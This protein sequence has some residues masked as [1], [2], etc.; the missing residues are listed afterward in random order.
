M[1]EIKRVQLCVRASGAMLGHSLAN[2]KA[3]ML[4]ISEG[5]RVQI[6]VRASGAMPGMIQATPDFCVRL[7]VLAFLIW[8][9]I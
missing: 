9:A 6:C 8:I 7:C 5:K 3:H 4:Y 1:S 2:V